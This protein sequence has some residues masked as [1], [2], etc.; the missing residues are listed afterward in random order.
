MP[1]E[2]LVAAGGQKQVVRNRSDLFGFLPGQFKRPELPF[3]GTSFPL[4]V[5][6]HLQGES[7]W[8][9]HGTNVTE[10]SSG[11]AL[12]TGDIDQEPLG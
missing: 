3:K 5:E 6:C 1:P 11:A 2:E 9:G 7:S 10:A 12:P 4:L 8:L